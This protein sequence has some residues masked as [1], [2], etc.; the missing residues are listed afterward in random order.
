[1]TTQGLARTASRISHHPYIH[2]PSSQSTLMCVNKRIKRGSFFMLFPLI[3]LSPLFRVFSLLEHQDPLLL[4][5]PKFTNSFPQKTSSHPKRR[6]SSW[7][8]H[9]YLS[10]SIKP[11]TKQVTNTSTSH[12]HK[13][14]EDQLKSSRHNNISFL[15]LSP[16]FIP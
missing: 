15:F 2:H 12:H 1:M 14:N 9:P 4:S 5:N 10:S 16:P 11:P 8:S 7:Y 6:A 3:S 13:T